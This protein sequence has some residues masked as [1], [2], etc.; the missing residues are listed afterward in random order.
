[1]SAGKRARRLRRQESGGVQL[2]RVLHEAWCKA[3]VL[4]CTCRP[5][6]RVHP[7]ASE[8]SFTRS[9]RAQAERVASIRTSLD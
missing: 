3:P 9:L 2:V 8:G 6:V 1:M 5:E 4:A 7:N